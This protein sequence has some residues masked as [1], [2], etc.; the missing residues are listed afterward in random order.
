MCAIGPR[1]TIMTNDPMHRAAHFAIRH[2]RALTIGGAIW[3]WA[4]MAVYARFVSLPDIP[5]WARQGFFWAGVAFNAI[6]WGF[7]RP[8]IAR[9][10]KTIEQRGKI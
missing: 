5:D 9:Y 10:T 1:E 2:K 4:S 6:W 8:Q 7:V 3:F